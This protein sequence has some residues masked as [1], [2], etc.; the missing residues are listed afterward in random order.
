MGDLPPML[1]IALL[2]QSH[3][4]E[5]IIEDRCLGEQD[6]SNVETSS[7]QGLALHST[8]MAVIGGE[9]SFERVSEHTARVI[10]SLPFNG[11]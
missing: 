6:F 8:L 3:G 7:G 1:K 10:L 11:L 5:I 2:R 9:L 4:W